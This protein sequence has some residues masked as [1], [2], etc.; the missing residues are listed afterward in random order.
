MPKLQVVVLLTEK[1]SEQLHVVKTSQGN[2]PVSHLARKRSWYLHVYVPGGVYIGPTRNLS[3][4]YTAPSV[5]TWIVDSMLSR[6][7]SGSRWMLFR[8]CWKT[9]LIYAGSA[10]SLGFMTPLSTVLEC[11]DL[12]FLK[13]GL[14]IHY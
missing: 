11:N 2:S 3:L 5:L 1:L 4:I 8:W 14:K 7:S 6:S 9:F 13:F 12:M 10:S